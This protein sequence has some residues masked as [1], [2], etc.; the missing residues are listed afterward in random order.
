MRHGTATLLAAFD[1]ATGTLTGR[2]YS[3]HRH[4][5][6]LRF[7][8][9]I[10]ARY[11]RVEIHLVL[12][13]YR[14]HKHPVVQAW[15]AENQRFHL[16]FTPTSASWMNQVETWFSILHR[17]AIQRGGGVP[18]CASAGRHHPAIHRRMGRDQ[19][20]VLLDKDAQRSATPNEC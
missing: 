20:P 16:H 10:A 4:E 7:L 9:V 14:T 1:I 12:D 13:N 3:R 17:K 8:K 19:A 5:E 6:F 15:L 11:P 18:E 2:T